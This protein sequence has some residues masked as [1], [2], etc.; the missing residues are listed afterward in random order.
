MFLAFFARGS[1][2]PAGL[3]R[4]R[5]NRHQVAAPVLLALQR[6]RMPSLMNE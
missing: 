4:P 2:R 1:A 6:L 5:M 3:S